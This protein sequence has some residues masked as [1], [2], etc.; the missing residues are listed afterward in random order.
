MGR[1]A[2]GFEV[3]QAVAVGAHDEGGFGGAGKAGRGG[4]KSSDLGGDVSGGRCGIL[5][6]VFGIAPQ[7]VH[8]G[9]GQRVDAVMRLLVGEKQADL[10]GSSDEVGS[11]GPR[12]RLLKLL[13]SREQLPDLL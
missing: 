6:D 5:F 2:A 8:A 9:Q 4:G 13:L 7:P 12:G 3:E 10:L 1:F 11:V